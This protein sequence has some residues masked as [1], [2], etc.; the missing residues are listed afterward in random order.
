MKTILNVLIACITLVL[1]TACA[2]LSPFGLE[3]DGRRAAALTLQS[4]QVL[5]QAVLV[6]ARLPACTTP[7]V[8]HLC[9][10][11]KDWHRIQAAEQLATTAIAAAAPVLAATQADNGEIQA[12]LDAITKVRQALEEIR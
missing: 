9:R 2:L 1:A 6:Y 12:A 4:Y 5:Q 10:N 3:A 7:R 11:D 8:T